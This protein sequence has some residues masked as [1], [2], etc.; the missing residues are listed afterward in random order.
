MEQRALLEN[1]IV[2]HLVKTFLAI[3]V[4]QKFITVF[5]RTRHWKLS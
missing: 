5:T 2:A 3:Y 4:I 1:L